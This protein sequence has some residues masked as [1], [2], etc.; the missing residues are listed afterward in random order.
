MNT[1]TITKDFYSAPELAKLLKVNPS[2]IKRWI[3]KKLLEAEK[4]PGGHRRISTECLATFVSKQKKLANSSYVISRLNQE[5]A[6][7]KKLDWEEYYFFLYSN[8]SLSSKNLLEEQFLRGVPLLEI[9]ENIILPVLIKVGASWKA[10]RLSIYDEHR[11]TFLLRSDLLRLDRMLPPLSQKKSST[12]VLAC[13]E[14]ENHEIPIFLLHLLLKQKGWRT[15]ILGIN[16][17]AEEAAKA[18]KKNNAQLLCLAKSFSKID[19]MAY[20]R[21]INKNLGQKKVKVALGGAGWKLKDFKFNGFKFHST[22]RG[23]S[24]AAKN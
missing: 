1:Q 18:V 23:L 19:E 8:T 12:A 9:I 16:T 17:P 15:I 21:K 20:L 14:D 10:G 6:L 7:R 3:D 13:V 24:E 4:T 5:N 11:M 22:F 2:T